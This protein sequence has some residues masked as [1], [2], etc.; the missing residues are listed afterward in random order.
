[1][2]YVINFLLLINISWVY[3]ADATVHLRFQTHIKAQAK[4]LGDLLQITPDKKHWSKIKL[5]SHA[6]EGQRLTK[7]QV[8]DWMQHQI[9]PFNYQWQGKN[10]VLVQEANQ[11]KA[12]ELLNKAQTALL[13]QLKTQT[14]TQ[15]VL[16]PKT[17][18]KDSHIALTHFTVQIPND[19]PVAKRVCVHLNAKK[20][21][22]PVWFS[23]KAYQKVLV[24]TKHIK[25]HRLLQ[26]N[27]LKIQ[28]RDIAGLKNPPLTHIPQQAWVK[29]SVNKNQILTSDEIGKQPD[30]RQ[31]QK[32][33]VLIKQVRI[34]ISTE[35]LAEH[36]AY[37][38]ELVRMKNL[39]NKKHFLARVSGKNQ[40]EISIS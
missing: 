16:K 26:T 3:G 33:S 40:V 6:K 28:N 1:M 2:K 8:I 23:V 17:Q 32:V 29:Q 10:S 24:A 18:L 21:S 4:Y 31:G 14:Y 19:Y 9:G 27:D 25:N 37:I 34:S 38:G 36:D 5:D 20:H 13:K 7:K 22:I 15:I 11:T 30:V 12:T 35:A 39:K